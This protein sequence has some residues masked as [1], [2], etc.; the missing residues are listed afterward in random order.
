M[1]KIVSLFFVATLMLFSMIGCNNDDGKVNDS[2]NGTIVE[3]G[4]EVVTEDVTEL[5]TEAITED[6]T[7][8]DTTDVVDEDNPIEEI[9]DGLGNAANDVASGVRDA[10]DPTA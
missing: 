10:V 8:V 3:N 6:V 7:V 2:S 9:G 5:A 4:T 1:K